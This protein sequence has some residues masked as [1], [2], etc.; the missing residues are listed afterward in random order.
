MLSPSTGP[1]LLETESEQISVQLIDFSNYEYE[2]TSI[3]IE[4]VVDPAYPL[5][6]M[7]EK[8]YKELAE[9]VHTLDYYY[10]LGMM[11]SLFVRD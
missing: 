10:K 7:N 1:F 9:S 5:H 4:C 11:T 6:L 8:Q 3:Q 2:E